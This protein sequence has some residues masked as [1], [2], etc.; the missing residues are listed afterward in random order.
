MGI[1]RIIY[2]VILAFSAFFYI[3][4]PLWFA[5]YLFLLILLI[6]P[7]DF[8]VSLP[9]ML[10][11]HI[12]LS[13]PQI[14][15][16]GDGGI[17][18]LTTHQAVRKGKRFPCK[19]VKLWMNIT[20]DDFNV[21]RRYVLAANDGS[22]FEITIDTKRTGLTTFKINRIWTVSLLGLFCLPSQVAMRSSV[23][24]LPPPQRPP[25]TV[26]LPR[27]IILR[28][29]PGGGFAE[30]YDLRPYRLGDPIRSVHWKVSAKFDSLIIRE[31]LVP[32]P[33]SRL[34]QISLWKGAMER[35]TILSRL[36]WVCDYL[37]KWELAHYIRLGE[38]GPIAE[39]DSNMDLLKYLYLVLDGADDDIPTPQTIPLR[40]AWVLRIDATASQEKKRE[41]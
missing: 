40:F 11:R 32:P 16:R 1:R 27:G 31:P 30:D 22:R 41:D 9:G 17:V 38:N 5:W 34:V 33:H 8:L 2:A 35:D 21:W 14:L 4:Y 12:T 29:K 3:L 25:N 20:G 15:E 23:L 6:L 39:I 26:I 18:V 37:L 13:S 28:P 36:R 24:I 19:C 7:F 10:T